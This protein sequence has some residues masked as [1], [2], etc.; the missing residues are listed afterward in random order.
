[1]GYVEQMVQMPHEQLVGTAVYRMD[2]T[3]KAGVP[4][5]VLVV[6]EPRAVIPPHTHNVDAEMFVVAGSAKVISSDDAINGRIV[7]RGDIVFFERHV[8][9]GFEAL[10]AG[11]IFVSRNGGIVDEDGDWDI[12]FESARGSSGK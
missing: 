9:H 5:E 1:M 8:T 7:Q 4:Q 11:L 2:S 3:A 12:E 6:C 10:D